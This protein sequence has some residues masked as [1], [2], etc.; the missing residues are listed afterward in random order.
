MKIACNFYA[1]LRISHF[2]LILILW[3][4]FPLRKVSKNNNIKGK[5][6]KFQ[7]NNSFGR[8]FDKF[9]GFLGVKNAHFLIRKTKNAVFP[10]QKT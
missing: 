4:I 9:A 10:I 7:V 8:I 5:T 2:I 1:I 6:P 3:L